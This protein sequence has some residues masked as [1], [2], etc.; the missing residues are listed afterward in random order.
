MFS[1]HKFLM[2]KMLNKKIFII[3]FF[4]ILTLVLVAGVIFIFR[5]QIF[6]PVQ[7]LESKPEINQKTVEEIKPK[8]VLFVGDIMLDR[9]VEE[10]INKNGINY[11]FEKITDFL[12]GADIVFGN[13][14]GPIVEKPIEFP[15]SSLKFA[16]SSKIIEGLSFAGFN[17]LSLANNHTLNMKQSG[18]E[19]TR[20][21]LKKANIDFVGDTLKC[22]KELLYQ[23]DELIFLAF[24]KT[25]PST[26]PEKEIIATIQEVKSLNPNSF[27][28]ISIHWGEEYKLKNS[29]FQ[30]NLAY[31]M[32]DAGADL[33]I[34]HHPH[35]IQSVEIYNNKL[36]FYSLGNFIFDQYFSKETQQG[37]LVKLEIYPDKFGYKLFPIQSEVSQPFLMDGIGTQGLL[38]GL[39]KRSNPQLFDKIKN[40]IIEI[41]K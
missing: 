5:R 15:R 22:T 33:I 34:G 37:L 3:I 9:S 13:L 6:K 14:E 36:I 11:P 2:K 12:K 21:N 31:K 39:A 4:L 23:K 25:F 29:S 30:Q 16:F 26:C 24:N 20:E 17:L 1:P 8:T 18:L 41:E 28:I 38:D 10:L 27:L 7:V 35:V 32:I 19:E 40:G